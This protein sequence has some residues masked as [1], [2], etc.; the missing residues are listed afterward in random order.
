MRILLKVL[1][2]SII[3]FSCYSKGSIK[4]PV[5]YS[6]CAQ[7]EIRAIDENSIYGD[8]EEKVGRF[9]SYFEK[10]GK[11]IDYFKDNHGNK[12]TDDWL[13][14]KL[15]EGWQTELKKSANNFIDELK[16]MDEEKLKEYGGKINIYAKKLGI[17][18]LQTLGLILEW[19]KEK[20][21]EISKTEFFKN[22]KDIWKE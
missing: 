12:I 14:S 5:D 3:I 21:I 16:N 18:M 13:N 11:T 1:V 20:S 17:N 6:K 7:D 15:K 9:Y 10:S 4:D 8:V 22:L 2:L 19:A